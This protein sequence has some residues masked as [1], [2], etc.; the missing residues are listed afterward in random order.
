MGNGKI[1]VTDDQ[2]LESNTSRLTLQTSTCDIEKS[3]TKYAYQDIILRKFKSTK[4]TVKDFYQETICAITSAIYDRFGKYLVQVLDIHTWPR[5]EEKLA[6]FG[7]FEMA[8]LSQ[9]FNDILLMNGTLLKPTCDLL[10]RITL[11]PLILIFGKLF[12]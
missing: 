1:N 4:L 11:K 8:Q 10:S 3:N 9:H 5:I 12:S 6:M 2:S 7:D